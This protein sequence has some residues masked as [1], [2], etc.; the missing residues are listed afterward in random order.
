MKKKKK[1]AAAMETIL[2]TL[3][4]FILISLFIK[5]LPIYVVKGKVDAISRN[6]IR[7]VQ[8]SGN[9]NVSS[10]VTSLKSKYKLNDLSVTITPKKNLSIG[11][12]FYID[13]ISKVEFKFLNLATF[14]IDVKVS[15]EGRSEVY[16]K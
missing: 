16:I 13:V 10:L 5:I 8:L 7:E 11:E 14:E 3:A 12:K 15:D 9:T 6:I 2:I 1:G 4:I